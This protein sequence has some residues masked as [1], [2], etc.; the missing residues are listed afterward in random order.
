[1]LVRGQSR[2]RGDRS[3]RAHGRVFLP[4]LDAAKESRQTR[5]VTKGVDEHAGREGGGAE[6]DEAGV[7]AEEGGVGELEEG[8]EQ[9]RDPGS[10]GMGEGEFVEVVDVGYGKVKGRGED[11]LSRKVKDF[12]LWSTRRRR[13]RKEWWKGVM[14]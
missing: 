8:A 6:V 13:G 4:P 12:V 11:D 5:P 7:P 14:L 2:R 10:V 3:I 9:D 1:M